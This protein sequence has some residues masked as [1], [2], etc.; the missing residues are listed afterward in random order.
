MAIHELIAY[1]EAP[2]TAPGG[3]N[4]TS[5]RN[6]FALLARRFARNCGC[7]NDAMARSIPF[8]EGGNATGGP[9]TD[10]CHSTVR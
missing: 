5:S 4:L 2:R 8:V 10:S 6:S 3:S 1:V 9:V 7:S